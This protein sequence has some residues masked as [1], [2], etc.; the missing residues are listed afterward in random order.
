MARETSARLRFPYSLYT[1]ASIR[2]AASEFSEA[3]EVSVAAG[4]EYG[5]VTLTG[6]DAEAVASEFAN[7]VLFLTV[8]SR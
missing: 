6:P 4:K 5:E 8:Q 2:Q 7:Y 3:A 1:R